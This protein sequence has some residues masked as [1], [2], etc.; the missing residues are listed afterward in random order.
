MI[1]A[2]IPPDPRSLRI[3]PDAVN[4]DGDRLA[5]DGANYYRIPVCDGGRIVSNGK[6]RPWRES[7]CIWHRG[8]PM[9]Y[10]AVYGI[11]AA[12]HLAGG[13]TMGVA[14]FCRRFPQARM[15]QRVRGKA[16]NIP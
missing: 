14:E 7:E 4:R 16:S 3:I 13:Q 15:P 9:V 5:T 10:H 1:P 2:Y 6:S 11:I 12:V 8:S